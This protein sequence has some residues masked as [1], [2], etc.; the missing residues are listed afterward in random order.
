MN[1][2]ACILV[3]SFA[4]LLLSALPA[5]AQHGPVTVK[6]ND[7]KAEFKVDGKTVAVYHCKGFAKPI[8][9]PVYTPS[10]LSITRSWPIETD[11]PGET[12]DHPHQKSVWFCHGDVIPEGVELKDKIKGVKGVDFWSEA[13]GHGIIACTQVKA[14]PSGDN[15]AT[16]E[17]KN[18]WR[19]A[20][21]RKILDEARRVLVVNLGKGQLYIFEIDLNASVCPII[22]GDTK[23]G[24]M[25]VRVNDKINEKHS[26]VI[27]NAEGLQTEK[28]CW[29]Q[30]S[31][32]CDYSGTIDGKKGGIA[33]FD[34]PH[35]NTP[36]CWH[37]RGYGLMG[38]NPFGRAHSGFPAVRGKT[39][40]IRLD[41]GEHLRLRYG[42]YVHDGDVKSGNVAE[43]YE[44]FVAKGRQK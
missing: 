31:A 37:S 27:T 17:T 8:L 4:G 25:A 41:R 10:R 14:G 21:G 13:K 28:K 6:L 20:D 36:V 35:N 5:L 34:D 1:K 33:I 44:Q 38:A 29:G 3:G 2:V 22:F 39:D 40:L 26:G 11:K 32:W 12:K 42:V 16:I 9:Y 23:E 30:Q 15:Y 7:G 43:A 24:A 18:E 19:T